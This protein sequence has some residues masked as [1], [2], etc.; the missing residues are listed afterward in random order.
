MLREEI[1]NITRRIEENIINHKRRGE[2]IV[3]DYSA[4]EEYLPVQQLIAKYKEQIDSVKAKMEGF[5]NVKK[6][7]IVVT[8]RIESLENE[9]K[10]KRE[11]LH[12]LQYE[13]NV[14]NNIQKNHSRAITEYTN[15]NDTRNELRLLNDKLKI[16]KEEYRYSRDLLKNTDNKVR[17]Q[18]ATVLMI[19]EKCEK[20]KA[21][22]E[23]KQNVN[24]ELNNENEEHVQ[25][26]S[27]KLKLGEMVISNQEKNYKT[28]LV[29]QKGTINSLNDELAHLTLQIKEKEQEMRINE[30]KLKELNKMRNYQGDMR[31][32]A[33]KSRTKEKDR[34]VF[35][36]NNEGG[37]DNRAISANMK[38]IEYNRLKA[39]NKSP[40]AQVRS[41]KPFQLNQIQFD[42]KKGL[43]N[44]TEILQDRQ[45][46]KD[47]FNREDM[48][49]Q[50]EQL[51]KLVFFNFL[52]NEIK[53]AIDG[54]NSINKKQLD[55]SDYDTKHSKLNRDILDKIDLSDIN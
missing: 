39:N 32:L 20:I 30:L 34:Q 27:E 2:T 29:K 21:N 47:N 33:I 36:Y 41:N 19:E 31:T 18:N 53:F 35:S 24:E 51:S 40:G 38:A 22:I 23:Y 8:I 1:A 11:K 52:E 37:R 5:Y 7:I 45:G 46:E 26:F 4:N 54:D 9:I 12:D 55:I 48:L 6:Y 43:K 49:K 25:L 42:K 15:K 3:E 16:I 50:I 44:H 10:V 28:E 17:T 14:L 13:F